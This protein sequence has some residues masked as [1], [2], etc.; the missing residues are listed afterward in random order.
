MFEQ[1][2]VP[3]DGSEYADRALSTAIAIAKRFS[4]DIIL[5]HV[6]VAASTIISSLEGI[7]PSILIDLK[8]Q[9]EDM[10]KQILENG[11][12]KTRAEGIPTITIVESGNPPDK[13]LQ[14]AEK[15]KVDLIVI[16]DRGLGMV[17]RF[18]LG[19]VAD[20]VTRYAKCPVLIVKS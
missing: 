3:L 9:L 2:L 12:K 4:S 1:I 7:G 19:S 18:F 13:I 14:I 20:K 10:G 5:V 17:A 15:R 11:A 8:K 6:V 16:G